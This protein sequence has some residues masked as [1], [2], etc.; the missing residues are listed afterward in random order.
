MFGLRE[1]LVIEWSIGERGSHCG[2]GVLGR[3]GAVMWRRIEWS[4]MIVIF[5]DMKRM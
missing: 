3:I 2:A 5:F 4:Q 1:A